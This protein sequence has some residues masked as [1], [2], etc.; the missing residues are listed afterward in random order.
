MGRVVIGSDNLSPLID[1]VTWLSLVAS[2]LTVCFRFLIK[3]FVIRKLDLDDGVITCS[4]V[5]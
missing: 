4:L 1:I 2:A 5:W 3:Y